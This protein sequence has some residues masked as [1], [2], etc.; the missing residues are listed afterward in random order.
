[1]CN[2][3]CLDFLVTPTRFS[4][5]ISTLPYAP[6]FLHAPRLVPFTPATCF[7]LPLTSQRYFTLVGK[8]LSYYS[9]EEDFYS[10]DGDAIGNIDIE[11]IVSMRHPSL[12]ASFASSQP[13]NFQ[14]EVSGRT[15]YLACETNDSLKT[16]LQAM[17]EISGKLKLEDKSVDGKQVFETRNIYANLGARMAN[18]NSSHKLRSRGAKPC[19]T[20]FAR[21]G[22]AKRRTL[23]PSMTLV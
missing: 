11:S 9:T 4:L 17:C 13:Y 2:S 8:M 14:I 19:K 16:W 6:L 1:M 12:D 21:R 15:W 5:L 7:P 23:K 10:L 20:K 3:P 22:K 18:Y